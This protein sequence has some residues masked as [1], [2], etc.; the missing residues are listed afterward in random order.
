MFCFSPAKGTVILLENVRF[1]LEEEGK[2]VD[3]DGK[4]IKADKEC[5]FPI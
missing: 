2:G 1:H 5:T 4:K 3:A